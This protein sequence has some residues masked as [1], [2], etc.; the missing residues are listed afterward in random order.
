MKKMAL[1]VV[2]I[3]AAILVVIMLSFGNKKPAIANNDEMIS[4]MHTVVSANS[5][6]EKVSSYKNGTYYFYGVESQNIG[7]LRGNTRKQVKTEW[8]VCDM[9]VKDDKVLVITKNK[10]VDPE[11]VRIRVTL[12]DEKLNSVWEETYT[13]SIPGNPIVKMYD[14][15]YLLIYRQGDLS[16]FIIKN[17]KNELL[18]KH[19]FNNTM[20]GKYVQID[21][22]FVF[23]NRGVTL[24]KA[25]LTVGEVDKKAK[26]KGS[27]KY[28]KNNMD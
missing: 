26:I 27:L 3:L 25:N 24:A 17:Y 5:E 6:T 11:S 19:V 4:P 20:I 10:A 7:F 12:Y 18:F 23:L 22:D 28:I 2:I 1:S 9:F 16:K 15:E 14:D 13:D 21:K 8:L